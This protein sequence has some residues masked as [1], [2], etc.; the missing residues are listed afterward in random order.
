MMPI[1]QLHNSATPNEC[2]RPNAQNAQGKNVEVGHL[3]AKERPTPN[4]RPT[5]KA[6][7]PMNA[8]RPTAKTPKLRMSKLGDLPTNMSVSSLGGFGNR[9]FG[10]H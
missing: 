7:R 9:E 8:Q 3:P 1:P 6:Q 4:E 5:P 2:P 10:V